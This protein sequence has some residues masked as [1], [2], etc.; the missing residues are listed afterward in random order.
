MKKITVIYKETVCDKPK[1]QAVKSQDGMAQARNYL[2]SQVLEHFGVKNVPETRKK[3]IKSIKI[4][5]HKVPVYTVHIDVSIKHFIQET[6]R[7]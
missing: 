3:R 4:K 5:E 7:D 6:S 1:A 2:K